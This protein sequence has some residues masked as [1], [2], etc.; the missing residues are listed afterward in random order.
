M[1]FTILILVFLFGVMT[2]QGQSYSKAEL[3]YKPVTLEEAVAQL[4]KL[5]HD[6]TKQQIRS[7]TEDEFTAGAHFGLGMWMRNN[8]GLWKG[9]SLARY[10]NSIGI[11]HPDDMSG[12]IL[13]SYHRKLNEK[14]WEIDNQV[15]Y[16]QDFWRRSNEHAHKLKTD[17]AYQRAMQ[18]QRD[19]LKSERL[20][21]KQSA[22]KPGT[23]VSGYLDYQCGFFGF[24]ERTKIEGTIV[25]WS[26]NKLLLKIN[27]YFEEKKKK[28]VTKCNN[29]KDDL[30]LIEN[31]QY[32]ETIE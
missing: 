18:V 4:T 10:F 19:S 29:I 21:K 23:R 14:E 5:H 11:Y 17:T 24:G 32:F 28:R 27:K 16:Y 1:K 22:W 8:W 15:K 26:D 25:E 31:H 30:V 7:M 9:G 13:T 6:T 20:K 3:K 2:V 12:I